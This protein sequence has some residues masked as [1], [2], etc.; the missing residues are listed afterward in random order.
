MNITAIT[1]S[2]SM[3]TRS[4]M[5]QFK[6]NDQ[7]LTM[8]TTC[9]D[10]VR[11]TGTYGSLSATRYCMSVSDVGGSILTFRGNQTTEADNRETLMREYALE[12]LSGWFCFVQTTFGQ[13][14]SVFHSTTEEVE[15][16][17]IKKGIA[18]AFQANLRGTTEETEI[19]PQSKHISHYSYPDSVDE[20]RKMRRTIDS[21]DIIEFPMHIPTRDV[22]L[23]EEEDIE[24][25]DGRL[26][27]SNGT[28]HL[29]IDSSST[30]RLEGSDEFSNAFT[31]HGSF[32]MELKLCRISARFSR[33]RRAIQKSVDGSYS[34]EENLMAT[35]DE[36]KMEL[37]KLET[38]R[39]DLKTPQQVLTALQNINSG[40]NFK[41][42]GQVMVL[43]RKYGAMGVS[44]TD[45]VLYYLRKI[46]S[47]EDMT[48]RV[49]IYS[50]LSSEGSTR[51]ENA[52]MERLLG[53]AVSELE[54]QSIIL[55]ISLLSTPSPHVIQTLE[56]MISQSGNESSTLL[57]AYGA[58]VA[59][60]PSTQKER[61]V[62]FMTALLPPVT[63]ESTHSVIHVLH[64][65]GNTKSSLAVEH[66]VQY[67]W[68]E[69][70]DVRVTAVTA[71]RFFTARPDTQQHLLDML[72]DSSDSMV[73][74]I[75]HALR[76]GYEYNRE[77]PLDQEL[78]ESL[79]NITINLGN[80]YLQDE[81]MYFLRA[82]GTHSSLALVDLIVSSRAEE[83]RLKRDTSTIWD[84]PSSEYDFIC[85]LSERQADVR[86]F[87]SHQSCLWS[88]T[89]GKDEGDLK[90]YL[91]SGVGL[92]AG[93][94]K[95]NCDLKALGKAVV[96]GHLLGW[97]ADA[98]KILGCVLK[99]N[100]I[101]K[102]KAY[103]KFVGLVLLDVDLPLSYTYQL[104]QYD[105][106]L[107]SVSY[108]FIVYIVPVTLSAS[109][110]VHVGGQVFAGLEVG[111]SGS[112]KGTVSFTP[113]VTAT[114]DASA[115]ASIFVAQ[116]GIFLTGTITYNISAW[117]SV[118]VCRPQNPWFVEIYLGAD[119][120]WSPTS[121]TLG[122][123]YQLRTWTFSW[124]SRRTWS[125]LTYTWTLP[126]SGRLPLIEEC[127][128]TD[129][130][131]PTPP[132]TTCP[133]ATPVSTSST[134]PTA[135]WAKYRPT[136]TPTPEIV[137][138]HGSGAEPAPPT[139]PP[140]TKPK[141][142][143]PPV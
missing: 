90:V 4:R 121:I 47:E 12:R 76:D 28:L 34:V 137:I 122:A 11:S 130:G 14:V 66:I 40:K 102:V 8:S 92:F 106:T 41:A 115:S 7:P 94:N 72:H 108:T 120:G 31:A 97:E 119:H 2:A 116:V 35:F 10:H 99:H 86:N 68:H 123:F 50:L 18:S 75:I 1:E 79:A 85:P 89:V 56:E 55:A 128:D 49:A 110:Q 135:S 96:R 67:L 77:M 141:P 133:S 69:D 80:Y 29:S 143:F 131:E 78:I 30:S 140:L 13:V 53:E 74:A 88:E 125:P 73:E 109:L 95:C 26:I 87:P 57:L 43:E 118:A 22:K 113:F 16:V 70:E 36:R 25:K 139:K 100:G 91:K 32:S 138:P 134:T 63:S 58:I 103:I 93:G 104:P 98:V 59:N 112:I 61:M 126:G 3:C 38:L 39:R 33:K 17:N 71:L 37:E 42:L 129:G 114:V 19:D 23:H 6:E 127:T 81:L 52:L 132:A 105:L 27:K 124:G 136:P 83:A 48:Q 101:I 20:V 15:V 142:F 60:A 54:K 46:Q 82:V 24:Y 5:I 84:D 51:A 45:T 107:F 62:S 111:E 44:V 9:T 64:A 21:E 65:L 117:A